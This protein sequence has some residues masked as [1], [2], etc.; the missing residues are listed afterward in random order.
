MRQRACPSLAVRSFSNARGGALVGHR[1]FWWQ[2]PRGPAVVAPRPE[3]P[4]RPRPLRP[5]LDTD[6]ERRRTLADPP[7][8]LAWARERLG[9]PPQPAPRVCRRGRRALCRCHDCC[10]RHRRLAARQ[11]EATR[12]AGGDTPVCRVFAVCRRAARCRLGGAHARCLGG[13]SGVSLWRRRICFRR[14]PDA[15]PTCPVVARLCATFPVPL[16]LPTPCPFTERLGLP[17]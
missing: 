4:R 1:P 6:W 14:Q 17:W 8:R 5:C 7:P 11:R 3:P 12:P 15:L 2:R 16:T 9:R 10:C 13:G